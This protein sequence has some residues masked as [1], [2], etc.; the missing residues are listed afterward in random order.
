MSGYTDEAIDHHGVLDAETH[1]IAKPFT[2]SELMHKV[3]NTL[4][5]S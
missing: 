2:V 1:F 4:D 3:R 5:P